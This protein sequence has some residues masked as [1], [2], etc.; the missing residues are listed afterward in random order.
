VKHLAAVL[1]AFALVFGTA[2]LAV[3]VYEDRETFVPGPDVTAEAFTREVLTKR[4]DRAKE[5]LAEPD[6]V[7]REELEKLQKQLGEV[8]N[9]ETETIEQ[10][11]QR[12]TAEVT[13]NEHSFTLPLVWEGE[14]K[15][16]SLPAHDYA[17]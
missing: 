3:H 14:W 12:A 2:A 16:A 15:V 11:L 13:L 7:S 4:W 8:Q 5:Y 6:S 17:R 9:V 10:H 1:V